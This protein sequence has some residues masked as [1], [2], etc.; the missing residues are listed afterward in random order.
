MKKTPPAGY[1]AIEAMSKRI[2]LPTS[3]QTDLTVHDRGW[4]ERNPSAPFVWIPRERGT[5]ICCITP[6]PIDGAG[7]R[8]WDV[9]RWHAH[10]QLGPCA[11]YVWTGGEHGELRRFETSDECSIAVRELAEKG[12]EG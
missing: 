12:K 7:N 8:A 11:F 1:L 5:S 10:G 2:M 9:P 3:F 4:I 6:A